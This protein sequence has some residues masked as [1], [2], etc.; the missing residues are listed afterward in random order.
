MNTRALFAGFAQDAQGR[1]D[2]DA[3]LVGLLERGT[4]EE[5]VSALF[6]A[7][8]RSRKHVSPRSTI[9]FREFE[10]GMRELPKVIGT[11]PPAIED[12]EAP[13]KEASKFRGKVTL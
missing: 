2:A 9:S 6:R 11:T 4:A 12:Q 3:L 7:L 13:P 1:I 8:S 5:E 10:A